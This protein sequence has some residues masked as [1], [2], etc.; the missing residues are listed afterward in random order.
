[1]TQA[2]LDVPVMEGKN[3]GIIKRPVSLEEQL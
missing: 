1:M 2:P 3:Q